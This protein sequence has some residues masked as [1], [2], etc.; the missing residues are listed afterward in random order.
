MADFIKGKAVEGFP[1]ELL[2]KTTF[3]PVTSGTVTGYIVKDGGVQQTL[4]NPFTHEGNGQWTVNLSAGEMNADIVGLLF[5]HDDAVHQHFSIRTTLEAAAITVATTTAAGPS[6]VDTYGFYGT[7]LRAENYFARRL[8]TGPWDDA[9]VADRESALVMA[10]R[11]IDKLNFAGDKAILT[12]ALQ[13]PRGDDTVVP[14]EIDQAGYEIALSF[15]DEYDIEQESQTIGV[16]TEA[17]SGVRTTYDADYVPEHTIAGIPSIEAWRLLMPFL[18][19]ER[20]LRVSRV[21]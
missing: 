12:Q 9:L 17:Y 18:R 21:S 4:S 8:N 10:A 2:D 1:F 15:L 7:L 19:D 14:V 11:A 3:D 6:V 5:T 13:F 20:V 16:L